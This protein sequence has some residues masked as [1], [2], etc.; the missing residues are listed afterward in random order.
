MGRLSEDEI[1]HICEGLWL[2]KQKKNLLLWLHIPNIPSANINLNDLINLTQS[3]PWSHF[4]FLPLALSQSA[5]SV[6]R[7]FIFKGTYKGFI[8]ELWDF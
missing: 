3:F 8:C 1:Y 7:I 2:Q 4:S 6:E 5:V